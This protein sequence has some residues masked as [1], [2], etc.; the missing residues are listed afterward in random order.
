MEYNWNWFDKLLELNQK[1]F[2]SNF[3]NHHLVLKNNLKTNIK[4]KLNF[5]F[6]SYSKIKTIKKLQ[7]LIQNSLKT[8]L[9][10][11]QTG[12]TIINTSKKREI[13]ENLFKYLVFEREYCESMWIKKNDFRFSLMATLLRFE[14]FLKN[15]FL[16][17]FCGGTHDLKINELSTDFSENFIKITSNFIKRLENIFENVFLDLSSEPNIEII[18]IL[19]LVFRIYRLTNSFFNNTFIEINK[20]LNSSLNNEQIK[21]IIDKISNNNKQNI[22][23]KNNNK[24]LPN[25]YNFLKED[26][27]N[28]SLS[29]KNSVILE[30]K[31]LEKNN[32]EEEEFNSSSKE[33]WEF[34]RNIVNKIISKNNNPEDSIFYYHKIGSNITKYCNNIQKKS[35]ENDLSYFLKKKDRKSTLKKKLN[36]KN[37]LKIDDKLTEF[38]VNSKKED[39]L[40]FKNN[41]NTFEIFDDQEFENKKLNV[42]DRNEKNLKFISVLAENLLKNN[43]KESKVFFEG[44]K[45]K[46]FSHKKSTDKSLN[47]EKLLNSR[48]ESNKKTKSINKKSPEKNNKK[49]NKRS[50]REKKLILENLGVK[51]QDFIK[52]DGKSVIEEKLRHVSFRE[53]DTLNPKDEDI[54]SN[55]LYFYFFLS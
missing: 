33:D 55:K 47:S 10:F 35:I 13:F 15:L 37:F 7:K 2:Y 51:K 19:K 44:Q 24:K 21:K 25:Y 23:M 41:N 22:Q 26:N 42:R 46:R 31:I 18:D 17:F 52:L 12:F 5:D 3:E 39:L 50:L 6:L 27:F 32:I 43:D 28:I 45:F 36:I 14:L 29:E 30:N 9:F 11:I 20:L 53:N 38:I 8:S 4:S 16:E 34:D 49:N 40:N 54:I 48:E 1:D